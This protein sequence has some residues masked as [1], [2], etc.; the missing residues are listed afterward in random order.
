LVF[1]T[2]AHS[3]PSLGIVLVFADAWVPQPP[4]LCQL[5]CF[6]ASCASALLLNW[7]TYMCTLAN[8]SLT[9]SVVGRTKSIVQ[10]LGGLFAFGDVRIN[11][12]N[13]WGVGVNSAGIAW[14][15]VEKGLEHRRREARV[16]RTMQ[17]ESKKNEEPRGAALTPKGGLGG[18]SGLTL[19]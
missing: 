18:R 15:T 19:R 9:T 8:D 16:E 12:L 7:A 6:A 1:A 10:T 14:Y 17:E 11:P 13:L 3:A 2:V 5:Q 4:P